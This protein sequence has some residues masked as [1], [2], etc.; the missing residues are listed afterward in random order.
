[1]PA[2]LR[3]GS[4]YLIMSPKNWDTLKF[5]LATREPSLKRGERAVKLDLQVPASLFKEPELKV[6][7]RVPED[8]VTPQVLPVEIEDTISAAIEEQFGLDVTV[9]MVTGDE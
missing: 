9:N 3:S 6:D 5:R 4:C 7:I 8:K 1:M 2:S